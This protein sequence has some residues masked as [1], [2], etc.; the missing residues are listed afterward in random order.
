MT[1]GPAARYPFSVIRERLA[2][3][4]GAVLDFA[5]GEEGP[6]APGVLAELIRDQADLVLRRATRDEISAADC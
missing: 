1:T 3:H 6:A 4:R 2:R 5:I